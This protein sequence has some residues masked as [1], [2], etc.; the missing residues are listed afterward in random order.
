MAAA[1]EAGLEA[2]VEQRRRA[3]QRRARGVLEGGDLGGGEKLGPLA[4]FG[5]VFLDHR[6]QSR[7]A[8]ARGLKPREAL[9]GAVAGCSP[10]MNAS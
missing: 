4:Q 6:A 3:A 10:N 9:G 5:E 1:H 7:R 8:A 2:L